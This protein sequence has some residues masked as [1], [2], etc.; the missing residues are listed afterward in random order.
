M[1]QIDDKSCNTVQELIYNYFWKSTVPKVKN[2]V[3]HQSIPNGG[4]KLIHFNYQVHALRLNWVKRL[5]KST[6]AK[7]KCTFQQ[8]FPDLSIRDLFLTRCCVD[9][10][11]LKIPLFYKSVIQAWKQF[12]QMFKPQ[13]AFDI[14]NESLWFNQFI[15]IEKKTVF[16]KHWYKA[17]I[18]FIGDII[19]NQGIFLSQEELESLMPKQ[20]FGNT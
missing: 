5:F 10:S 17:G 3:I 15:L 19:N 4:L 18:M 2:N 8:F 1:I 14:C 11:I 12:R 6:H 13:S 9:I 16:H 7:W 20:I